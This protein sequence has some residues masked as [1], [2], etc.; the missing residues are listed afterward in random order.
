MSLTTRCFTASHDSRVASLLSPCEVTQAF[1]PPFPHDQP[2][3][4]TKFTA[5]WDTGATN[6]VITE[7]VVK[8]C[9]LSPI[10]MMKCHTGNGVC[11]SLTYLVSI[12]L[13]NNVVI[14]SLRVASLEITSADVLIGM[15]IIAM[16]DFAISNFA[17]K[18][19]FSFRC[20]SREKIDFT[21]AEPSK[22][23]AICSQG[24]YMRNASCACGSGKK[25]KKCCGKAA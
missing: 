1:Q 18:T 6:T 9:G 22:V 13:P 24:G 14:S 15:D 5:L 19:T 25:W 12:R 8:N 4:Y 11:E 16:G 23:V 7:R 17:G 3:A 20:P 2:S 21:K 10:G